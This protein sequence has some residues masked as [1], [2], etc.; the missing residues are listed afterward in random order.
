[1][2]KTIAAIATPNAAGGIGIIRISGPNALKA[3]D[4]IFKSKNN[5]KLSD[6][7]GYSVAFGTVYDGE[8]PMDQCIALVFKGPKSYTGEDIVELQCHGGLFLMKKVLRCV[9]NQGVAPA[10]PGEFTKRAFLNGKLDLSEAESVMSLISAK[11]EQALNAAYNALDGNL[12]NT[13]DSVSNILLS[14]SS[15]MAVWIDYPDEEFDEVEINDLKSD[16]EKSLSILNNLLD[17]FDAG[18][19]IV[20][21]VNTV[22]VGRPNVGKST[23]MNLLLGKKRSIVTDIAGTTRDI[24]EETA[25]V[26]N[27]VLRLSDT[28][29]LHDSNDPV[30]MVGIEMAEDRLK[31][32][33]LVLAVLD[34]NQKMEKKDFD[35]LESCKGKKSIGII[36]KVDLGNMVTEELIAPYVT[37]VV[38]LS[39][40]EGDGVE[41]LEYTLEN[42]LGTSEFD[43]STAMLA[44]ERQFWCCKKAAECLSEAIYA[45]DSGLTYDAVNVSVDAALE[46]LLELTGEKVSEAVVDKIFSSF[47]VGK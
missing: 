46:P 16:L 27:V 8:T 25:K 45:I 34:G 28:A 19:A 24:I 6:L 38:S 1:M 17:R 37:E 36:N 4:A 26:G 29:G 30:E 20:S 12:K 18:Q 9:L 14:I 31:H 39:A 2:N 22:I 40:K 41:K 7:P 11:G 3:A 42:I 21:G 33:D 43:P 10:G 44:N 15:H 47:C 5:K 35:L 32:A 23:L 13:I